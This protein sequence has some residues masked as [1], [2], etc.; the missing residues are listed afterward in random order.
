MPDTQNFHA[1]HKPARIVLRSSNRVFLREDYLISLPRSR[2]YNPSFH[3]GQWFMF[4]MH[5]AVFVSYN[6]F[7]KVQKSINNPTNLRQISI[8]SALKSGVVLFSSRAVRLGVAPPIKIVLDDPVLP[9]IDV[10]KKFD[11]FVD[12]ELSFEN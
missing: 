1:V 2:C 11:V 3:L 6:E 9:L 5:F 10:R 8:L 7:R 12:S 4:P